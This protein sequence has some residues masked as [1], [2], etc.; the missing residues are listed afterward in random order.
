MRKILIGNYDSEGGLGYLQNL[1][2]LH[3]TGFLGNMKGSKGIKM[4]KEQHILF[5]YNL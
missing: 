2:V 5:Q 1:Y 4:R 3:Q